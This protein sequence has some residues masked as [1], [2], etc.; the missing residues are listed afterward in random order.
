MLD[1]GSS[2]PQVYMIL[3]IPGANS[4]QPYLLKVPAAGPKM[5][6]NM[7]EFH[8][9]CSGKIATDRIFILYLAGFRKLK[10]V[11]FEFAKFQSSR[12]TNHKMLDCMS[13]TC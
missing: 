7:T 4:N 6:K 8:V 10:Y 2:P 9:L 12:C 13:P 1:F 11:F 5:D 3:P